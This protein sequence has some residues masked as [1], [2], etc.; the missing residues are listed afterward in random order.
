MNQLK[1]SVAPSAGG[2]EFE[3]QKGTDGAA[4][5]VTSARTSTAI[6]KS[7]ST[8]VTCFALYVGGTG[9]V[10][11]KHTASG[12]TVTYIGVPAGTILRVALTAGR[13]M[14]ATTATNIVGMGW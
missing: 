9:D 1:K 6:T 10:A 3:A 7:D 5:V 2:N 8:E 14:A 11:I 13:V 4:H 12:A